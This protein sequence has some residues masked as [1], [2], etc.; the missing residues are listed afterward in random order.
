MQFPLIVNGEDKSQTW[1]DSEVPSYLSLAYA[2]VPNYLC[3]LGA[4]GPIAH[5]SNIPIIE[6]YTEYAVEM[7]T[8]IQVER[9][10]AIR[11]KASATRHFLAHAKKYLQH[12]AWTGPCSSWFKGGRKDGTPVR[13]SLSNNPVLSLEIALL[14]PLT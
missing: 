9:I 5:G 11:P 4:Y 2:D 1:S 14:I 10:K 3:F 6:A 12:T 7:I 13:V 8:K